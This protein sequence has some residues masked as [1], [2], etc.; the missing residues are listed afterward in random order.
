VA[1]PHAAWQ[2]FTRLGEA[3]I[4]LPAALA[5]GLW[6]AWR[7]N[8]RRFVGF[9]LN[10]DYFAIVEKRVAETISGRHGANQNVAN[11]FSAR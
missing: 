8:G 10:P 11:L 1:L 3:Q 6:L 4:L 2:L 5:T 9:E 7:W